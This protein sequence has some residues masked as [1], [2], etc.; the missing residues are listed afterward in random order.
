MTSAPMSASIWPHRRPR[1]VVRSSTRYGLRT[2]MKIPAPPD[3]YHCR[4]GRRQREMRWRPAPNSPPVRDASSNRTTAVTPSGITTSPPASRSSFTSM[5][6][7]G[8]GT[9]PSRCTQRAEMRRDFRARVARRGR[10][11]AENPGRQ[12]VGRR[13]RPCVASA[14]RAVARAP[15]FLE[16]GV[17]A[18]D[19]RPPFHASRGNQIAPARART[20]ASCRMCEKNGCAATTSCSTSNFMCSAGS[21]RCLRYAAMLS[22]IVG[23]MTMRDSSRM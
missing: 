8:V 22:E 15:V 17:A 23:V 3:P 14:P 16:G 19:L 18:L 10:P 9:R 13:R 1:S 12:I 4:T 5:R 11:H 21:I 2:D 6:P 7:C 20:I